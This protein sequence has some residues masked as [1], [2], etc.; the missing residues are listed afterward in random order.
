M[1]F[2]NSRGDYA[3]DRRWQNRFYDALGHVWE[4]LDSRRDLD[5][6]RWVDLGQSEYLTNGRYILMR[7]HWGDDP[8]IE[9]LPN[10]VELDSGIEIQWY[11][12]PLRDAY[13]NVEIPDE[14]WLSLDLTK[15]AA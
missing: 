6:W 9:R 11:K 15:E 5:G 12:Y 1:I 13:S 10:F 2:G 8:M 14:W 7:Y 3:I 4:V